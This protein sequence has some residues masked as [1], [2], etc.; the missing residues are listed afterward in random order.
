MP[1]G[2]RC[3]RRHPFVARK[4][5]QMMV[6]A[7]Q[8]FRAMIK[9]PR[10]LIGSDKNV[11]KAEHD[12]RELVRLRH[13]MHRRSSTT[14]SVPSEPTTARARLK[15]FSGSKLV[16]IVA[17]DSARNF[18]IT[19]PHQVAVARGNG[20]QTARTTPP[21]A[22]PASRPSRHSHPRHLHPASGACRHRAERRATRH[23]RPF[24]RMRPNAR[25]RNCCR[26]FRRACSD[27]WWPG[28]ERRKVRTRS[29]AALRCA[30]TSPGW[31]IATTPI[32][33]DAEHAIHILREVEDQRGIS[34]LTRQRGAAAARQAA[35]NRFRA[36]VRPPDRDVALVPRNDHA[37]AAR[38]D[39]SRRR[40]NRAR[41]E[42][43][44]KRTSPSIERRN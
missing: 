7:L 16:E 14:A 12:H 39:N 36:P 9:Q 31:T 30:C 42:A 23:C 37:D 24:C 15:P 21:S 20:V 35:G 22:R 4:I 38:D 34:G 29:T 18:R 19:L 3:H 32:G 8:R 26:S 13:Q 1:A 10:R 33:I 17:G 41:S 44:S 2:S 28:R 43:P 6:E 25:R 11:V 27:L 40:S 5:R